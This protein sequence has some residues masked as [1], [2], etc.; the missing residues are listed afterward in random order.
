[1]EATLYDWA[2]GVL[3]TMLRWIYSGDQSG[4][5]CDPLYLRK[6]GLINRE[7]EHL[8]LDDTYM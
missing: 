4:E 7:S 5:H 2:A 1:M 8:Y 3:F 6:L